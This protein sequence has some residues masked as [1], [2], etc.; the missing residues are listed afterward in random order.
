MSKWTDLEC[1]RCGAS[2]NGYDVTL[3]IRHF[4]ANQPHGSWL[5]YTVNCCVGEI[6]IKVETREKRV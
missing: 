6:T 5:A 1:P 4:D 3:V 2:P